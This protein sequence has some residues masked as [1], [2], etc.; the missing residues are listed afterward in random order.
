MYV[1]VC[2]E[3][4]SEHELLYVQ[5][6]PSLLLNRNIKQNY[7]RILE[8]DTITFMRDSFGLFVSV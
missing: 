1:L 6:L 7:K 8:N 3:I 2:V 5:I 4:D